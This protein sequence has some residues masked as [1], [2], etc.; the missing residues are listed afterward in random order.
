MLKIHLMHQACCG[1]TQKVC[2][3]LGIRP[4]HKLFW[5]SR[6]VGLDCL[7]GPQSCGKAFVNSTSEHLFDLQASRVRQAEVE[8][9]HQRRAK[10]LAQLKDLLLGS[11]VVETS[12]VPGRARK[13][14]RGRS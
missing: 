13:D 3:I 8:A 12:S 9:F 1:G 6:A 11:K 10:K 7:A 4:R 5:K 14:R 2:F